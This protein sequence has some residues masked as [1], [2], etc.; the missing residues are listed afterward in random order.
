MERH[1]KTENYRRY[2]WMKGC[3]K[4]QAVLLE[5]STFYNWQVIHLGQRRICQPYK[6]DKVSPPTSR[7]CGTPASDGQFWKLTSASSLDIQ[8]L[9]NTHL[10]LYYL[11]RAKHA[12]RPLQ[13]NCKKYISS[14]Q[15]WP[16]FIFPDFSLEYIS[17]CG[18]FYWCYG[19]FV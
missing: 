7:F 11:G 6:S 2:P 4:K 17:C 1:F 15:L 3:K 12:Y 14:L 8:C 13:V 18:E 9:T 10:A 19:L 5:L 16:H